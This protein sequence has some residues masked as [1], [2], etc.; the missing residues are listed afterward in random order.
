MPAA[1]LVYP[2]AGEDVDVISTKDAMM[3]PVFAS[4]A[5]LG[6]YIVFK[7]KTVF[8]RCVTTNRLL[9]V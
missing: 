7:V 1:L 6:L 2:Q 5:L 3:F 9:M 8:S 4:C